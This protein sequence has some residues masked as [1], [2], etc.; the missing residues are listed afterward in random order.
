MGQ[1]PIIYSQATPSGRSINVESNLPPDNNADMMGQAISNIGNVIGK[2][3]LD[4]QAKEDASELS[5]IDRQLKDSVI[6]EHAALKAERDAEARA[7]IHQ[8]AIQERSGIA[9]I[10]K[11]GNVLRAAQ[12]KLDDIEPQATSGFNE[13]DFSM[14]NAKNVDDLKLNIAKD[15]AAGDIESAKLHVG[16][17]IKTGTIGDSEGELMLIKANNDIDKILNEERIM[18]VFSTAVST[19]NKDK[20]YEYMDSQDLTS[21]QKRI[22]GNKID[23]YWEG[24]EKAAKKSEL[25]IYEDF[26]K[27]LANG[28]FTGDDINF[29]KLTE[30]EKKEWNS[31]LEGYRQEP[32]TATSYEGVN[33]AIT[34]M[35]DVATQKLGKGEAIK[36]LA[37]ERYVN[38][39]ITDADYK[40]ALNK[41]EM[42]YPVHVMQTIN[43]ILDASKVKLE[44]NGV[45]FFGYDF[46]DR[47]EKKAY[48]EK[49]QGFLNWVESENKDGKYPD[50]E[51]MY[52][53]MRELGVSVQTPKA[54]PKP[55]R[56]VPKASENTYV[57]TQEQA[58][59]LPSGTTFYDAVT[60]TWRTKP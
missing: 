28:T 23:D 25:N 34:I 21:E 45:G 19:E 16:I 36:M 13:I 58:D 5:T 55:P 7:K 52:K 10:S 38:K 39:T 1:F 29:S 18:S 47:G 8:K 17:A 50:G 56:V 4:M 3:G 14:R 31:V 9:G 32:P 33:T 24:R 42:P 53:K 12:M 35:T 15:I 44:Q 48:T 59:K 51:A 60:G 22:I 37:N 57:T 40:F 46:I 26:S 43:G 2:I 6:A 27:K 49:T 41:I 30:P 54:L 20:S 11:R